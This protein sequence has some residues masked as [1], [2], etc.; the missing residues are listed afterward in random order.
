MGQSTLKLRI[1]IG[2]AEPRF[3]PKDKNLYIDPAMSDVLFVRH[4]QERLEHGYQAGPPEKMGLPRQ[5]V[6]G[7]EQPNKSGIPQTQ[8]LEGRDPFTGRDYEFTA[9]LKSWQERQL[10]LMRWATDDRFEMGE[11]FAY[12]KIIA[13][14]E[15]ATTKDD[16]FARTKYKPFLTDEN[17]K[18]VPFSYLGFFDD[19]F[20]DHVAL[21]DKHAFD[22]GFRVEVLDRNM[23]SKQAE[24]KSLVFGG[25]PVNTLG[26]DGQYTLF[27][28]F[29]ML[30]DAPPLD[31]IL[32]NKSYLI[33]WA[34]CTDVIKP[35]CRALGM[36]PVGFP[37]FVLARG[38]VSRVLTSR[39]I[40]KPLGKWVPYVGQ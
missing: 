24:L 22:N 16:P 34:T 28:T 37:H 40:K 6:G 36:D 13:G 7:F 3:V 35:A 4:D 27:E 15:Y 31:W 9:W 5:R 14:K 30:Q 26:R 23:N 21:S 12:Y 1:Q 19:A 10:E 18:Y 17:G 33:S 8:N 11:P 29:D 20:C 39:L 32:K 25:N 2:S 38:G